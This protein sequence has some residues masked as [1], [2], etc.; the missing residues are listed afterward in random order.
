MTDTS[1]LGRAASLRVA[2]ASACQDVQR[3]TEENARL[4]TFIARKGTLQSLTGE[5]FCLNC[6]EEW[7][8][9]DQKHVK[10]CIVLAAIKAFNATQKEA[11][12]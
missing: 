1:T 9:V 8:G 7:I 10:D 12:T 3:L 6:N 2:Y 4:Q 11:T 5:C